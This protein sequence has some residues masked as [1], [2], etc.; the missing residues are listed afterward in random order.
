MLKIDFCRPEV[1]ADCFLKLLKTGRNGDAIVEMKN[2]PQFMYRDH[3]ML[4]VKVLA[5]GAKM[6]ETLANVQLFL[7]FTRVVQL[8]DF[9][10]VDEKNLPQETFTAGIAS[11][12]TPFELIFTPRILSLQ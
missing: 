10:P 9:R 11:T 4:M 1:V 3:S 12:P 8:F 7:Y 6:T 5:V 2:I